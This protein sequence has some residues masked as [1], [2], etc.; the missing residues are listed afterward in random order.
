VTI[1]CV[2]LRKHHGS[3]MGPRGQRIQEISKTYNVN[4]KIPERSAEGICACSTL[5]KLGRIH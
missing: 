1:E 2:V 3:I 5:W 4:I